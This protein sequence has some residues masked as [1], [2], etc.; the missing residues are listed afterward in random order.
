MSPILAD[1]IAPSYTSPYA[2]GGE[3][4]AGGVLANEYSCGDQLNIIFNLLEELQIVG[5]G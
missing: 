4:A 3:G 2:G 5:S 1:K